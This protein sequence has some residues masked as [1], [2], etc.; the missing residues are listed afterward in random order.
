LNCFSVS[1]SAVVFSKSP[2]LETH[3]RLK[4]R[5]TGLTRNACKP[6]NGYESSAPGAVVVAYK[7]LYMNQLRSIAIWGRPLLLTAF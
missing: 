1:R 6:K 2:L 3:S 7:T 5:E 4:L